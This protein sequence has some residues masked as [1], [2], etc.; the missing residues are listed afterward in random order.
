M[1]LHTNVCNCIFLFSI[2]RV[3]RFIKIYLLFFTVP[4]TIF[5]QL[6]MNP[7]KHETSVA[8]VFRFFCQEILK[9]LQFRT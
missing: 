5:L 4:F 7:F 8:F 9:K 2:R 1:R 3:N 6:N